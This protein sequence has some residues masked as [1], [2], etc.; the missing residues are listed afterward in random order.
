MK[1][2]LPATLKKKGKW[3]VSSCPL[4]DVKSQGETEEKAIENLVEALTLFFVSCFD[5]GAL[6]EVLKECGFTPAGKPGFSHFPK[7]TFPVDVPIPFLI[8]SSR[9]GCRA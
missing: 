6:D 1:F 9:H 5:R 4:L 7:N 3:F 8:D 2:E